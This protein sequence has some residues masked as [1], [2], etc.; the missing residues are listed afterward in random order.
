MSTRIIFMVEERSMAA[1]LRKLLP[2]L[3]PDWKEKEHWIALPHNGK[4]DLEKSIPHKLKTWQRPQDK[5]VIMRDNDGGDCVALKARLLK[6][7]SV[8]PS[9]PVLIRI[10]CQELESWFLGDLAAVEAAY[11]RLPSA[12]QTSVKYRDPDLMTNAS[13]ELKKLTGVPGKIARAEKI[14]PH[15][16]TDPAKNCS[17]SFNA[18]VS[19]LQQL[20]K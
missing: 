10:V 7:A 1:T 9:P 3:F 13:D 5:F 17:Q 2:N 11:G 18:F 14:A 20:V 19:G 4:S 8:R 15:L 16:N 12:R 6:L